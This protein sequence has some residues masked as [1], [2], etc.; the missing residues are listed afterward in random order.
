[1][2]GNNMTAEEMKKI[3]DYGEGSFQ[4][5]HINHPPET[6]AEPSLLELLYQ[7]NRKLDKL[8][9]TLTSHINNVGS[10]LRV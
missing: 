3:E 2:Q 5:G 4:R 6:P 10:I 1:M 9:E 7:I 8:Q